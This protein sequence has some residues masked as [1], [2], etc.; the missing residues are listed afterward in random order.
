M[1]LAQKDA[2]YVEINNVRITYVSAEEG[3]TLRS[4]RDYIALAWLYVLQF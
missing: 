2:L 4:G 1:E 3:D